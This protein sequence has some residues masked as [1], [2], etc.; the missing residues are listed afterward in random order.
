[1][2]AG[3]L[4]FPGYDFSLPFM[5]QPDEAFFALAGQ[6][7]IDFGTAKSFGFHHYPPGI[8]SVYYIL[9]RFFHDPALPPASVVWIVRLI[10][11]TTSLGIISLLGLFGY[12]ALGRTAG[13]LGAAFWAIIP[14]FVERSR[15][16]TAEIFV[17]FF[18]ILALYLTFVGMRYRR[19]SWTTHGTYAL[20]L[21][22]L[23]KYHA[24][25]L[26][27]A[28][29]FAPLWGGRISKRRVLENSGRMALF[30]AWLLL[31]TPLLDVNFTCR[32]AAN[33]YALGSPCSDRRFPQPH[34]YVSQYTLR[35]HVFRLARPI[36]RLAGP[37]VDRHRPFPA[38]AGHYTPSLS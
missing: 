2:L 32:D 31:L 26:I 27:P 8:I 22:I 13:L 34:G 33:H 23:F 12:H 5:D 18:S 11:T 15:W 17:T 1:M 10:A 4:R 24:L 29:L 7:I 21:A 36:T 3:A 28:V 14:L 35:L 20:I 6:L 16:G 19:E 9:L 30:G 37:G 25:F 38:G